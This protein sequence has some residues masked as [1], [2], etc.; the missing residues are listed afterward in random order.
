MV[1][2]FLRLK[3]QQHI[4]KHEKQWNHWLP[5]ALGVVEG[6]LGVVCAA[7]T[8]G[9][10]GGDRSFPAATLVGLDLGLPPASLRVT[11]ISRYIK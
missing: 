11:N 4:G 3:H 8:G 7:S 9:V 6:A 2:L 1:S 5:P 10:D